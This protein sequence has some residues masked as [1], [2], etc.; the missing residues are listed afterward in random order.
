MFYL[1]TLCKIV[2]F[3]W[4]DNA[5]LLWTKFQFVTETAIIIN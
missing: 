3:T 1:N 2:S 5:Q 4:V